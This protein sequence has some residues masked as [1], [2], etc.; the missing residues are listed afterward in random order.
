[1]SIRYKYP[2][3]DPFYD[4]PMEQ[5]VNYFKQDT[6]AKD[7]LNNLIKYISIDLFEHQH[8]F[9]YFAGELGKGKNPKLKDNAIEYIDKVCKKEMSCLREAIIT[10]LLREYLHNDIDLNDEA[11]DWLLDEGFSDELT[12]FNQLIPK[13]L[14]EKEQ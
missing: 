12:D 7:W 9:C 6:L 2:E 3:K 1:M 11:I 10:Y 8:D 4:K 5:R 13:W 14:K